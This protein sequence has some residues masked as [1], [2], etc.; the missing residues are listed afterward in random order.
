MEKINLKSQEIDLSKPNGGGGSIAFAV[1]I[2][3][4][5]LVSF[6]GTLF[7]SEK[8]KK[9]VTSISDKLK[10]KISGLEENEFKELYDFQDRILEL[11]NM[12]KTKADYQYA[13]GVLER[14][15]LKELY[16]SK[17]KLLASE[18]N[19]PI[20]IE[21]EMVASGYGTIARQSRIF[22]SSQEINKLS[23]K[24]VKSDKDRVV[25]VAILRI[26]PQGK[27]NSQEKE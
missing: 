14:K 6:V 15:T 11:E 2:I 17:L 27:E 16:Y 23:L 12:N 3:F 19:E 22:D 10:E 5:S 25:A 7:Y 8:I 9:D 26:A 18:G 20:E 24:V 4:L 13:L 1:G 21:A